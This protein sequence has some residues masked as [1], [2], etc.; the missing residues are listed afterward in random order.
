ML[1][2]FC[3]LLLLKIQHG[4]YIAEGVNNQNIGGFGCYQTSTNVQKI[5]QKH[6][7]KNVHLLLPHTLTFLKNQR[8][9]DLENPVAP[10]HKVWADRKHCLTE[11]RNTWS[12]PE[13]INRRLPIAQTPK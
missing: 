2:C 4:L 5:S 1:L 13:V 10:P 9:A 12:S 7:V 8:G 3:A 11:S 6:I